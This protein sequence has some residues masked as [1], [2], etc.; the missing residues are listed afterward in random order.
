MRHMKLCVYEHFSSIAEI[1][2]ADLKSQGFDRAFAIDSTH[3]YVGDVMK[4]TSVQYLD[5]CVCKKYNC[6]QWLAKNSPTW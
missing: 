1:K 4:H 2:F 3:R 6:E 5:E